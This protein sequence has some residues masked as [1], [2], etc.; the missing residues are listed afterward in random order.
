MGFCHS[1]AEDSETMIAGEHAQ[2]AHRHPRQRKSFRREE[3]FLA[4]LSRNYLAI[5]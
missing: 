2:R 4:A 1:F 3:V 5:E